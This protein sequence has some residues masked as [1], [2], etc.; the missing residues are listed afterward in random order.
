MYGSPRS[1]DDAALLSELRSRFI[2]NA[3]I[4][5]AEEPKQDDALWAATPLVRGRGA[6]EGKAAAYVCRRNACGLPATDA[7]ALAAQLGS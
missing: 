4:V 1:G 2:P 3:V 5:R 7:A 6:I